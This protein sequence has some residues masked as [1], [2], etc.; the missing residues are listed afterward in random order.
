[1]QG[2]QAEALDCLEKAVDL[3]FGLRGWI[4]NDSDLISLHGDPRF[5]AIVQRLG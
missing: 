2:E 3:G 1:V 4:Q 5:E